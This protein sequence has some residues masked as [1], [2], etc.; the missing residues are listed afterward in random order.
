[1]NISFLLIGGNDGDRKA[2]LARALDYIEEAGCNILRKSALY[3][4]APWGKTD[5]NDFFN[6]AV[7]VQTSLD[8]STLMDT[9][10]G[11][12]EKMGRKRLEKYGSRIIDIDILF[13]NDVI[14]RLPGLIVP[15]PEIQNRRFVLAPMEEIA[16]DHMHPAL[17]R[18]IRELL[19]ICPDKLEVRKIEQPFDKETP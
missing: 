17:H 7:Q 10:L 8:A 6:Q 2:N 12:E 18:S 15:H 4:T 16:P 11:I 3:E 9:L 5:Q 13:F 1:M 14:I 19:E